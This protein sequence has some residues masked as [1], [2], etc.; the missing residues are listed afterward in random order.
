MAHF[1][2]IFNRSVATI[3]T[4]SSLSFAQ[5]LE[6]AEDDAFKSIDDISTPEYLKKEDAKEKTVEAKQ[7]VIAPKE[8]TE[9]SE[10]SKSSDPLEAFDSKVT[11][12]AYIEFGNDA[13]G[14][15]ATYRI[16]QKMRLDFYVSSDFE[17]I[18]FNGGLAMMHEDAIKS[19]NIRG[20]LYWGPYLGSGVYKEGYLLRVGLFAGV[21]VH[22][23]DMPKYG[24]FINLEPSST[25]FFNKSGNSFDLTTHALKFGLRYSL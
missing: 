3:I 2:R 9:K 20:D 6:S 19:G 8:K 12:G 11:V 17:S 25:V 16:D 14:M 24:F 7:A 15:H 13:G 18:L 10:T 4:L 5:M 22:L 23:E 1:I 21:G